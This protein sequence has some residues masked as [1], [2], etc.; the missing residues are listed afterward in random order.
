MKLTTQQLDLIDRFLEQH[1][2]D[3]L[4]FKLELKDHLA[5]ATEDIMQE[6]DASFDDAFL[7]ASQAWKTELQVKKY[8]L[9]SNERLFPSFVIQKIKHRVVFHYAIVLLVSLSLIFAFSKA[10]ENNL[11]F[12]YSVGF[13][14]IV[15]LLLGRI[16]NNKSAKTSFRFH[17]DYFNL[18]ILLVLSTF[19][20][21][22]IVFTHLYFTGSIVIANFPFTVYYFV[23][24]RQFIK[25]YNLT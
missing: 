12:K 1:Q 24:H 17:F 18:P 2:L 8:W 6:H 20:F 13:C 4:D 23:K 21:S 25:K 19:V 16:M 14:G 15:C 22:K 11:L 5:T 3:F 10:N 7:L 9:I